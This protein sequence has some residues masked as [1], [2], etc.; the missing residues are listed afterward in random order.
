MKPELAK[1]DACMTALQKEIDTRVGKT[2]KTKPETTKEYK[3]PC[4]IALEKEIESRMNGKWERKAKSA[5]GDLKQQ[6]T[7]E[8]V[9]KIKADAPKKRRRTSASA[10]GIKLVAR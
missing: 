1:K 4:M 9:G 8:S 2:C 3:D 5:K 10:K 6:Q 7:K